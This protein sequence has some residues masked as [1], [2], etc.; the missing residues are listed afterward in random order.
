MI[1]SIGDVFLQD[2]RLSRVRFVDSSSVDLLASHG[3][4]PLNGY[5]FDEMPTTEPGPLFRL[6]S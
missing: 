3:T 6:F 2:F 5:V 1:F 4:L